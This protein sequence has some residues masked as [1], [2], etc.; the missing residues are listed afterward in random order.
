MPNTAFDTEIP[1]LEPD[2]FIAPSEKEVKEEAERKEQEEKEPVV[3]KEY[4]PAALLVL[5]NVTLLIAIGILGR[6]TDLYFSYR[7]IAIPYAAFLC[8]ILLGL[9]WLSFMGAVLNNSDLDLTN[10]L[11]LLF[12]GMIV[13]A[14][15]IPVTIG[16]GLAS[17][18]IADAQRYI[19]SL[20]PKIEA[21]YRNTG[22][23]PATMEGIEI[24]S[25]LRP[26]LLKNRTIYWSTGDK[27]GFTF[28]DTTL[29]MSLNT[30]QMTLRY[31]GIHRIWNRMKASAPNF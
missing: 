29:E 6:G 2:A 13:A 15:L 11:R 9:S 20:V 21:S 14:L 12:G 27:Y 26:Q 24:P 22:V 7:S 25:A 31:S 1:G 10:C 18:D 3:H 23:Y 19:E 17:L 8:L 5:C 4:T 28:P 16:S 30:E